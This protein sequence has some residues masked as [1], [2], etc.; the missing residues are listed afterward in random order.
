MKPVISLLLSVPVEWQAKE[1]ILYGLKLINYNNISLFLSVSVVQ[2][3]LLTKGWMWNLWHVQNVWD[4][5]MVQAL[6]TDNI[7]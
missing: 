1:L 4:F 2:R 6:L 3:N 5:F 7:L